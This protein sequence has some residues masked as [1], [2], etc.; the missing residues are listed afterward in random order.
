[1]NP[2]ASLIA[3]TRRA[4][5]INYHSPS[6]CVLAAI[7]SGSGTGSGSSATLDISPV[8]RRN[9]PVSLTVAMLSGTSARLTWVRRDYIYSYVVFRSTSAIGP[10]TQLTANV[11]SD[12][13]V[14]SGVPA[15]TYYYK[16]T[17]IE[18]DAG[19]TLPSPVAGPII[20]A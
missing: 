6:I 12:N 1:M 13:Y 3:I 18:S 20:Y 7:S 15:G 19:E 11:I 8:E 17:G 5:P 10:F 2:L 16:V 14:D 9:G 4:L